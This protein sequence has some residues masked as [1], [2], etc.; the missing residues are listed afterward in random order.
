M[1]CFNVVFVGIGY[2][3]MFGPSLVVVGMYFQ[4]RR[5]LANGLA[6]AGGSLGQLLIPQLLHLLI[7]TYGFKGIFKYYIAF[8]NSVVIELKYKHRVIDLT[9]CSALYK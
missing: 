8:L 6:A 3:M 1:S 9:E 2:G 7:Q 4:K 5:S